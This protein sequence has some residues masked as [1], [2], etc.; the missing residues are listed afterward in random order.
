MALTASWEPSV[1]ESTVLRVVL[2]TAVEQS[3]AGPPVLVSKLEL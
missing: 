1:L 3:E 2:R